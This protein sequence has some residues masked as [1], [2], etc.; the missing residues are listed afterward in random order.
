[1]PRRKRLTDAG[2]ARLRPQAREYTLWDTG[3]AGLGVRVR[4]SSSRTFIYHRKMEAGVRKT[5]SARRRCTGSR[6]CAAPASRRRPGPPKRTM[7]ALPPEGAAVPGFCSRSM[8][9]GL[10]RALQAL[11]P[12]GVPQHAEPPAAPGLR[13]PA[14]RPHHPQ[15]GARLVRSGQ[16]N[17]A[18]G[19]QRGTRCA[20]SAA[21]PAES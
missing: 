5:P 14:S 7:P 19:R 4:P 12:E 21:I 13:R 9:G 2:I 10:F 1:M 6:R 8:E 18:G 17:R 20:A 11:H 16:P 3:V 15:H